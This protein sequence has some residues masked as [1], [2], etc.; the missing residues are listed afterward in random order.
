MSKNTTPWVN[1]LIVVPI[2]I[3]L[4][5]L[6]WI[7][8][9]SVYPVDQRGTFG[10]KFGFINSLFSG[11]ALAG[12]VYSIILQQ[13]ELSLQRKELKE[14]KEEFRDQNFQTTFFNLL[15]NQNQI[16]SAIE[17]SIG[18]L[19]TWDKES[20]R[21]F[22]GRR[23]FIEA[24]PE[25]KRILKALE[26]EKLTTYMKW[27]GDYDYGHAPANA[28][29]ADELYNSMS[30]SFT[31]HYYKIDQET[32]KKSKTLPPLQQA[33]LT[34]SIFF[35]RFHYT[36]GHYFRNIYHILL[37]L[38]KSETKKL[39]T[40]IKPE[41]KKKIIQEFLQYAE[42]LQA[43]MS[44]PEMLLLFYNCLAFPNLKRLIIKYNTLEN[45][46]VEDLLLQSHNCVEGINLK[47]RKDLIT[48]DFQK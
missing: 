2:V 37:F 23:F 11:L 3:G 5:M 26:S 9:D 13:R 8:I 12:I 41:E 47:S 34:Y 29:E 39:S 20:Y 40:Q 24:K 30:K 27:D 17:A 36:I 15:K 16:T 14:T 38:E 33:E 46:A 44:S 18:T 31:F 35:D 45:L 7:F 4:W 10:D 19:K 6:S 43:Q 42:F 48:K 22:N 32:L 25:L 1:I 21:V 28:Q